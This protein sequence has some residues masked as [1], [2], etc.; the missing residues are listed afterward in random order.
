MT[1]KQKIVI[2]KILSIISSWKYTN[3]INSPTH[4]SDIIEEL[5]LLDELIDDEEFNALDISLTDLLSKI[6]AL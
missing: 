2:T 5:R 3:D 1:P 6:Q 4:Y